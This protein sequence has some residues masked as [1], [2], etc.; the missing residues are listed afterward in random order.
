MKRWDGYSFHP[1][2]KDHNVHNT[3]TQITSR[4]P[5]GGAYCAQVHTV[6]LWDGYRLCTTLRMLCTASPRVISPAKW[7]EALLSLGVAPLMEFLGFF[8]VVYLQGID[9]LFLLAFGAIFCS[10]WIFFFFYV[11]QFC[12]K[13]FWIN[14]RD[15]TYCSLQSNFE[16]N[17]YGDAIIAFS[18]KWQIS[19]I[20]AMLFFV[21]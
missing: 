16:P 18:L 20:G 17:S 2:R 19:S 14:G 5:N 3:P 12:I 7:W 10:Y 1:G 4:Q 11:F 21:W 8:E 15:N 9:N 6:K 13:I